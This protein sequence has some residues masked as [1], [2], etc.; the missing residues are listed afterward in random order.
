[1]QKLLGKEVEA[2]RMKGHQDTR[3][4]PVLS[5]F[6]VP[7]IDIPIYL[8]KTHINLLVNQLDQGFRGT[9]LLVGC[10]IALGTGHGGD[11]SPVIGEQ[12]WSDPS[13]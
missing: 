12:Y 5:C 4:P 6:T 3:C 2:C 11:E 9:T 10:C 8:P 7:T 1:M 13:G